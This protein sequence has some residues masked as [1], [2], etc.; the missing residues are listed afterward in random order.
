MHLENPPLTSDEVK[1]WS[2]AW[3]SVCFPAELQEAYIHGPAQVSQSL[4]LLEMSK[5]ILYEM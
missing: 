2:S 3:L 4:Q 5:F 1:P